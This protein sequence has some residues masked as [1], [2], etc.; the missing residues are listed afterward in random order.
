MEAQ[1]NPSPLFPQPTHFPFPYLW[2]EMAF[3]ISPTTATSSGSDP[4]V[5]PLPAFEQ[6]GQPDGD[7]L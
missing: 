4:V 6:K 2:Q 7:V 3:T 1:P 5:H